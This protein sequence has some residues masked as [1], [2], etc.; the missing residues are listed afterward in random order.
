MKK[1]IAI[2][3]QDSV[4]AAALHDA[5]CAVGDA[6]SLDLDVHDGGEGDIILCA[7]PYDHDTAAALAAA[8]KLS[9]FLYWGAADGAKESLFDYKFRAPLRVGQLM[10]RLSSL[11][12]GKSNGQVRRVL[13]IKGW[14]IIFPENLIKA[15]ENGRETDLTDREGQI[16]R[17]LYLAAGEGITRQGLLDTIWAY[18]QDV[19][20]HTLETHIYRLR[21]KLEKDPSVPEVLITTDA[22]YVLQR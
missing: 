3:C 17:A 4:I 6:L 19:E 22:G 1:S 16:L 7:A 8:H 14:E 21:Q 13:D 12:Q 2:Y 15:K 18:H 10:D 20:T 9:F 5:A 11:L